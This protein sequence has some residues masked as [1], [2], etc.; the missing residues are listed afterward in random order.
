MKKNLGVVLAGLMIVLFLWGAFFENGS[1]SI[2]INGQEVTGPLKGMLGAGGLVVS[3]VA[4]S[5]FAIL[6]ALAF[7]G[8]GIIM[9]GCLII[10]MGFVTA[11]M[12]PFLLPVLVPLGLVWIFIA[13]TRTRK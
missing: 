10:G 11:L 9:L 6:L 1:T 3:L 7:A 5:C 13:L 4:L 12:F 8:T 2:I